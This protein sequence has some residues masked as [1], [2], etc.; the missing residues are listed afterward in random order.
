MKT[1]K[2]CVAA[3]SLG[4]LLFGAATVWGADWQAGAG[5][6]WQK[7]L[8]AAKREGRI[9]VAG[10]PQLAAPMTEG[11]L[12]DTGIQVEFLGGEAR[13][14]AS[15]V[16]REVRAGNVTI[17]AFFTGAVELP[18]VKEGFFE[19]ERSRLLLPGVTD[20]RNWAGGELKWIDNTKRFMLQTHSYLGAVPFYNTNFVKPGELTTWKDLLKPQFKGKIVIYDPRS[21]GPGQQ[22]GSYLASDLGMDFVRALYVGQSPVFSVDSRQMAEWLARGVHLVALGILAPDYLA[23]RDAGIKHIVP[24]SMKDGPGTVSGGFSVILLPKHAPHPNA[25]TVFLNWYAS[26]PGQ[27]VFS[28]AWSAPSRRTDVKI[29]SI[30][31]Y[32]IPKS[33][34]KYQDQYN[35]DWYMNTRQVVIKEVV[36]VIGGK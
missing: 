15:R 3:V 12:R 2:A 35:E 27:D 23:F 29:D 36:E 7:I 6:D 1:I 24:L 5:A 16:A 25:Q 13:T 14:T 33:G 26:Q 10:P 30:P 31:E 19:D 32:I 22:V 20:P 17:D 11:F 8:A 28:R 18:L 4:L 34:V 9:A 21:G